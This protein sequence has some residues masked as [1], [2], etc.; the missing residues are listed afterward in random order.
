[1]K[2]SRDE[3]P[4]ISVRVGEWLEQVD[5][6]ANRLDLRRSDIIRRAIAVYFAQGDQLDKLA[7][8]GDELERLR[9]DLYRVGAN[10]N[11]I[12]AELNSSG[13]LDMD[14]L[15]ITH[16]ELRRE[17]RSIMEYLRSLASETRLTG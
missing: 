7:G 11:Q 15:R 9:R 14:P 16:D 5:G 10:L 1:M 17:F 13:V 4:R 3:N 6:E 12:A 2:D 8:A